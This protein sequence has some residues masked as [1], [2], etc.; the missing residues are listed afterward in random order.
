MGC[1][2]GDV[3]MALVAVQ[4]DLF[5]DEGEGPSVVMEGYCAQQW[6]WQQ[7]LR[8]A[9][10]RRSYVPWLKKYMDRLVKVQFADRHLWL[11]YAHIAAYYRWT[12]PK[13]QREAIWDRE[14]PDYPQALLEDWRRFLRK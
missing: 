1:F 4:Y 2:K 14:S 3:D 12:A 6:I 5:F 8:Q 7:A 9:S 13:V 11:L 10:A